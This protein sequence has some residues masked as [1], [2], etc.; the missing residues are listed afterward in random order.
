MMMSL[1]EKLS[2]A[3]VAEMIRSADL[4]GNGRIDYSGQ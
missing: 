2:A 3:E 1:G 4:D